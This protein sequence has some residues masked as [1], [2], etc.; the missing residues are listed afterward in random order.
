MDHS[1]LGPPTNNVYLLPF[2]FLPFTLC[3]PCTFSRTIVTTELDLRTITY[4]MHIA[5]SMMGVFTMR[6]GCLRIECGCLS[7]VALG[8]D[9]A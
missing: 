2:F 9:L 1:S 4:K 3:V 7:S 5:Y 8:L 6:S